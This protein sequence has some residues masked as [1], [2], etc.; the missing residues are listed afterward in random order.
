MAY[1][2]YILAGRPED[3]GLGLAPDVCDGSRLALALLAWPG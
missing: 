1:Y 2:V 3:L